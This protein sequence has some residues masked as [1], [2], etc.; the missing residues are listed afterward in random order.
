MSRAP[1]VRSRLALLLLGALAAG[2]AASS[3]VHRAREAEHRQDYDGAVVEFTKAVRLRPNDT[4]ARVGLER[5]KLRALR[6]AAEAKSISKP[7]PKHKPT[8]KAKR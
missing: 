1:H 2:C 7:K 8:G 6:L 4:D 3:A 5:A